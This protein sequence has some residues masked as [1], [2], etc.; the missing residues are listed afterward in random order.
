MAATQ[1]VT[2]CSLALT[3]SGSVT[4]EQVQAVETVS[5][6]CGQKPRRAW[7]LAGRR[8]PGSSAALLWGAMGELGGALS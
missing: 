4:L 5:P 3:H 8:L 7:V 2:V 6:W 1:Q